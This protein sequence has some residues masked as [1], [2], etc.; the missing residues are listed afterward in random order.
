[1]FVGSTRYGH[2]ILRSYIIQP[3]LVYLLS[4]YSESLY[5]TFALTGLLIL[6]RSKSTLALLTASMWFS[7]ATLARSNGVLN[8]IFILYALAG[9]TGHGPDL[10]AACPGQYVV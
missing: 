6:E 5:L 1:M 10:Q 7:M 8:L 9:M 3:G 4:G 2:F